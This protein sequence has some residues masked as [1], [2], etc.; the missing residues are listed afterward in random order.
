MNVGIL[1]SGDVAK[2]LGDGFRSRGHHVMLGT[3]DANKL[4]EWKAAG[5]AN[6]SVGSFADAATFGE[7]V[8][9]ATHG[10]ATEEILRTVGA[11]AFDGKIVID[12]T[13][14]LTFDESGPHLAIGFSD[15]LGERVQRALPGARV[16]KAYNTVGSPL[17]IDP[18]LEGGPPD[19]FIAGND[20][21][22]KA[23]VVQMLREFGWNSIDMG[24]IEA[25]RLLEPLCMVWV[26]H[27]LRS[28]AWTHAFKFLTS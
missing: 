17:M 25:S 9:L 20:D 19:M 24:G 15:S 14:P 26:V 16:V 2:V 4:A 12:A 5:G 7:I 21:A 22:A 28:G 3:R 23:S 18:K 11:A 13:N 10:M 6:A 27:G 8:V 1:G